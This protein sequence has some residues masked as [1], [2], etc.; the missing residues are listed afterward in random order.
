M[1]AFDAANRHAASHLH[2][3]M[4]AGECRGQSRASRSRCSM[5]RLSASAATPFIRRLDARQFASTDRKSPALRHRN[6]SSRSKYRSDASPAV[7]A[8]ARL[9][10]SCSIQ[11][12]NLV[13]Q[14]RGK[15]SRGQS[16]PRAGRRR[17]PY[18]SAFSFTF[19]SRS[20]AS[21][22]CTL[23]KNTGTINSARITTAIMPPI[24]LVPS[25]C[26]LAPPAPV[27]IAIGSTPQT[28]ARP[29]IRIGRK[30]KRAGLDRRLDQRLALRAQILGEFD[31]QDGVLGR[32]ADDG[33]QA[34]GE[35]DVVRQAAQRRREHRAADAERHRQQHRER[36]G[37]AFIERGEQQEHHQHR[38]RRA[39]TAPA[40]PTAFP[41][42]TARSIHSRSRAAA[43]RRA[44]PSRRWRRRR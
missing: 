39:G 32:E 24:T 27:A 35:I 42:A 41:A 29:V 4:D 8:Q 22:R 2:R 3:R 40:S 6:G 1:A 19:A 9:R 13:G 21:T 17:R 36:N 16:A 25:A 38:Q 33:D 43:C 10:L 28:K 7:N 15:A 26:W 44:A 5:S 31:D 14:W 12:R 11:R 23:T 18:A 20:P 34:D 30:R 37:P